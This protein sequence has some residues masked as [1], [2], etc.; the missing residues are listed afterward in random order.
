M[1]N[2]KS[3]CAQCGAINIGVQTHCLRCGTLLPPGAP[4]VAPPPAIA[5]LPPLINATPPAITPPPANS[6]SL[7]IAPPPPMNAPQPAVTPPALVARF[8]QVENQY[9]ILKG[10]LAVGRITRAE[11]ETALGEWMVQDAQGRYWM[12]GVESGE[13]HLYDGANWVR[14]DPYGGRPASTTPPAGIPP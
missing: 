12:V 10:K 8:H 5:P 4:V 9:L 11:F 6:T 1:E 14:A 13:W 2:R 7:P 3:T